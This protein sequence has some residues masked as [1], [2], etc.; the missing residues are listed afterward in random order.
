MKN[1]IK[2]IAKENTLIGIRT[3][4]EDWDETVIGFVVETNE[5]SFSLNEIDEFGF[6]IGTTEFAFSD[7]IHVEFNDQYQ[8]NLSYIYKKS[9]FDPNQRKTIWKKGKEL[10]SQIDL[11]IKEKKITTLFFEE[12]IYKIGIIIKY[13][14]SY[15]MIKNITSEGE[16][17]GFSFFSVNDLIGLRYSGLN[18]QKIELL[19]N[20]KLL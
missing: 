7:I 12:D 17:D 18:E 2:E 3:C 1:L 14:N 19:Y 4:K 13:E 16:E 11:L 8:N 6:L 10:L 15:L 20:R 5:N 9:Q